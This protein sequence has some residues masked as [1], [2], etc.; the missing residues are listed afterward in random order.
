[1]I[2]TAAPSVFVRC[3]FLIL[4]LREGTSLSAGMLDN[5]R[6]RN[7]TPTGEPTSGVLFDGS[8]MM[9]VGDAGSILVSSDNKTWQVVETP[10]DVSLSRVCKSPD[11]Y[12]AVGNAG[13]I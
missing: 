11:C 12:I 4:I 10:V 8:K 7:P 6:Y 9:V 3:A 5:W 2:K 13:T 1:M